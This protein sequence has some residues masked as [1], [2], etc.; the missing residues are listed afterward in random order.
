M[1]STEKIIWTLSG[2]ATNVA[3][4]RAESALG[5]LMRW[6]AIRTV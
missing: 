3:P 5:S 4:A 2:T 1:Q 6:T